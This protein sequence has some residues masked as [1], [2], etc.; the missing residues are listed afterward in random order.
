[1]SCNR[2]AL[3]DALGLSTTKELL[4][5]QLASF[6]IKNSSDP[7]VL[8]NCLGVKSQAD[9]AALIINLGV[10]D[11]GVITMILQLA[12][13]GSR[14]G[15]RHGPH[16]LSLARTG[17]LAGITNRN[18]VHRVRQQR[19]AAK[20]DVVMAAMMNS[21]TSAAEVTTPTDAE[22][23][24]EAES[25]VEEFELVS[26]VQAA[27][28]SVDE[29]IALSLDGN[30]TTAAVVPTVVVPPDA[31]TAMAEGLASL[32]EE[33]TIEPAAESTPVV[34][35]E[36]AL[37]AMSRKELVAECKRIGVKANGK[38]ADLIARIL[39]A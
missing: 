9:A 28:V 24:A 20:S 10:H 11:P 27:P 25:Y 33:R 5:E 31:E 6:G 35:R 37:K 16:Y 18:I 19:G 23:E 36:D 14:V 30:G 21:V 1:M 32:D 17:K 39:A 12:F 38:D 29:V 13:P 8:V 7:F 3:A 2:Q 4:A 15:A 22:L 34:S 26:D